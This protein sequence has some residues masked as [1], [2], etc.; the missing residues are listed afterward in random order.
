MIQEIFRLGPISI[1]PFG[2]MLVAAF[3][4]GYWRLSWGLKRLGIGDSEDASSI[5]FAAG[6]G[7]IVGAKVYYAILYGDWRL[8][9]ERSGLV[10][11]GGFVLGALCV[12]WT[13]KRRR[14]PL[15]GTL[16][17]ATP[18][19]ALGYGVG[20]IGCFLVGDDYGRPTTLPWG[21]EFA[22]G[23]PP[24][25]A[26]YLRSE[27]GIDLPPDVPDQQLLAVHP[28]QLYETIAALVIFA[29]GTRWIVRR[30]ATGRVTLAVLGLLALERFGVEFLRAKDDRFLG[31][32]T[33]AQVISLA[34]IALFAVLWWRTQ[35]RARGKGPLEVAEV[36]R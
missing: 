32:L 24:T 14:L 16:D 22:N 34:L 7:G 19:L 20:R 10:W 21:V 6:I 33:I 2:V 1:S 36:P 25:T 15:W 30:A 9:L 35:A 11:Y 4:V 29:I 23:L 12:L 5:V 8:L 27:F 18:G 28:T 17:A 26:Y 3:A 31:P 13:L